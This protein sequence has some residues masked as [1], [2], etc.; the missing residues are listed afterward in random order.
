M[1]KKMYSHPLSLRSMQINDSFWKREMELVR[2]EVIPYQWEALNDRVEGAAPSFAMRN[3]KVAQKKIRREENW[4]MHLRNRN[5]PSAVLR[6]C[7]KI[8]SIWKI[9]FMDLS[10]RTVIFPNGSRRWVI[11]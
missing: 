11:L 5:I 6:H 1:D 4:E 9:N 3:F 10:F 7:R 2:K 8:R